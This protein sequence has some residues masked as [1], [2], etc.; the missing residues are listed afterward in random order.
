MILYPSDLKNQDERDQ[1]FHKYQTLLPNQ[2]LLL[3]SVYLK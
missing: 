3:V 2:Y 1:F